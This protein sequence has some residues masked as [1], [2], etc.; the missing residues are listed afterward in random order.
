MDDFFF[1]VPMSVPIFLSSLSRKMYCYALLSN[2]YV[3]V[4][5]QFK[6]MHDWSL[7]IANDAAAI[8][9][10]AHI[11]KDLNASMS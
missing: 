5:I 2:G 9:T 6:M 10:Y 4:H 3:G 8:Q 11:L 7:T 1:Q